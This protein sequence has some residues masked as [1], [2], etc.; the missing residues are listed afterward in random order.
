MD[1]NPVHSDS[2]SHV[3]KTAVLPLQ[4]LPLASSRGEREVNLKNLKHK[5]DYALRVVPNV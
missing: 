3:L 1:S 4:G 5:C 2:V